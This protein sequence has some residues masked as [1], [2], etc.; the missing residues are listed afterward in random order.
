M[1]WDPAWSDERYNHGE[2]A[3]S[4]NLSSP[5]VVVQVSSRPSLGDDDDVRT[6]DVAEAEKSIARREKKK[7]KITMAPCITLP[8]LA[9]HGSIHLLSRAVRKRLG[10]PLVEHC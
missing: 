2:E 9:D 1:G 4:A 8:C 5:L 6:Q 7:K 3:K 10:V